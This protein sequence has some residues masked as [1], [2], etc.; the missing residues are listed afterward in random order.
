MGDTN[1]PS[2]VSLDWLGGPLVNSLAY[3]FSSVTSSPYP[4][5]DFWQPVDGLNRAKD[6]YLTVF[7]ISACRIF[8]TQ[9]FND[10]VFGADWKC[11]TVPDR[12]CNPDPRA[13]ILACV[14]YNEI[15]THQ[16][17]TSS[18]EEKHEKFGNSYEFVREAM[19][20]STMF[21]ALQFRRGAALLAQEVVADY[22]SPPLNRDLNHW[23]DLS[24]WILE[25]WAM[26]NTSLAWIQYD[27]LDVAV[28]WGHERA[29]SDYEL[30][31]PEWAKSHLCNLY[32]FQLP[33]GY[34]NINTIGTSGF[35]LLSIF[36]ACLSIETHAEFSE[37]LKWEELRD[38][39]Q[40]SRM[41]EEEKRKKLR[42]HGNWMVLDSIV[43]SIFHPKVTARGLRIGITRCWQ[44]SRS[45]IQDTLYTSQNGNAARHDQGAEAGQE[46]GQENG[47]SNG[48]LNGRRV[49]QPDDQTNGAIGLGKD[50]ATP[51]TAA[52]HTHQ[53]PS[54][55]SFRLASDSSTM[56]SQP[57]SSHSNGHATSPSTQHT[58]AANEVND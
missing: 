23:R 50:P 37:E 6:T 4:E 16:G 31:T 22:D 9:A 28:G 19:Q 3:I 58:P 41:G 44:R 42:F 32:K 10:D 24:Q 53:S 11:P 14:D 26:F 33:K 20:K 34:T 36:I 56:G 48:Q 51:A 18:M 55:E 39:E 40:W 49:H 8:Y 57:S 15:R 2:K 45:W 43:W 13:R 12:Y 46:G 27:A 25:S 35:I 52:I 7:F 29:D 54:S 47:Q 38:G 17:H 30:D 1:L 21:K 5:E